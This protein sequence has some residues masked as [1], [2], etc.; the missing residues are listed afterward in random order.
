[1]S[2]PLLF[3]RDQPCQHGSATKPNS[4]IK[5]P[6]RVSYIVALPECTDYTYLSTSWQ[7]NPDFPEGEITIPSIDL[8]SKENTFVFDGDDPDENYRQAH[9]KMKQLWAQATA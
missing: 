2:M 5:S 7:D 8:L 1:M 3:R 9:A 4:N 6:H